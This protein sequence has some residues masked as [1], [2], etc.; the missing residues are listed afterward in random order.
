MQGFDDP[1]VMAA[2]SE[3]AD[4]PSKFNKYKNNPK[5]IDMHL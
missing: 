4:D 5:V 3:I 1:E 2:V